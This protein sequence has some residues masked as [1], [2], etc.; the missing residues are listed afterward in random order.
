MILSKD[1]LL[2]KSELVILTKVEESVLL[3]NEHA[4]ICWEDWS[5]WLVK[6]KKDV[7]NLGCNCN[8]EEIIYYNDNENNP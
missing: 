8:D 7:G 5:I 4:P 1:S 6:I 3:S 2:I